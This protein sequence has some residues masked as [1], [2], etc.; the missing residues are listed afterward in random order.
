MEFDAASALRFVVDLA[1]SSYLLYRVIMM[2]RGTKSQAI[3]VTLVLLL[4]ATSVIRSLNLTVTSWLLEQFWLAGILLLAVSFQPEIRK[5]LLEVRHHPAMVRLLLLGEKLPFEE[6]AY[7]VRELSQ[8]KLGLVLALERRDRLSEQ[9]ATGVPLQLKATRELLVALAHPSSP[10]R[11]GAVLVS[12]KGHI[13]AARCRL[14]AAKESVSNVFEAA[15]ELT[16]LRDSL[17]IIT[18]AQ[19]GQISLVCEGLHEPLAHWNDLL[20]R[21]KTLPPAAARQPAPSVQTTIHA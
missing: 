17:V 1:I 6:V 3:A 13:L 8:K 4:V 5:A 10:L 20:E 2:V 9:L 7:A 18:G 11:E 19:T 12:A 16:R 14:N 21:L 15:L